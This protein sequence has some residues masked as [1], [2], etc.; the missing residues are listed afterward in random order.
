M[1][2]HMTVF[3]RLI[4]HNFPLLDESVW[5]RAGP[6][7]V[8]Q[9]DIIGN[10]L[11]PTLLEVVEAGDASLKFPASLKGQYE[12]NNFFK[13]ILKKPHEF[14][15]FAVKN[16]LIFLVKNGKHTLCILD[17]SIGPQKI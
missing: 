6:A 9:E 13:D 14:K 7:Q 16:D 8:T 5:G 2:E 12:E 1:V 3:T 17:C 15:N 10:A 4:C 11:A